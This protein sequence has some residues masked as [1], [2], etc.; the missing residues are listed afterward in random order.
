MKTRIFK[1]F[2]AAAVGLAVLATTACGSPAATT[3]TETAAAESA[4]SL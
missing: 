4:V 1:Q 2:G 3:A